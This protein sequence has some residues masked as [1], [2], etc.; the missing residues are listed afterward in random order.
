MKKKKKILI[1]IFLTVAFLGKHLLGNLYLKQ[2]K[3]Q[4]KTVK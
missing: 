4:K 3:K 2:W 1:L